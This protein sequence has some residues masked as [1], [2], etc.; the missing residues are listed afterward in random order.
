HQDYTIQLTG[1]DAGVV[2]KLSGLNI[3]IPEPYGIDPSTTSGSSGG[4][5]VGAIAG[6][7]AGVVVVL[8]ALFLIVRQ[9]KKGIY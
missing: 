4:S 7:T 3:T 9:R 5:N 2:S 8:A 6:G 1:P